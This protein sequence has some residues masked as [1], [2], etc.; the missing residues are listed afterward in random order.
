MVCEE[1]ERTKQ[2]PFKT[3][4]TKRDFKLRKN[5]ISDAFG[6]DLHYLL[7]EAIDSDIDHMTDWL[8]KMDEPTKERMKVLR[9]KLGHLLA[10]EQLLGGELTQDDENRFWS[11]RKILQEVKNHTAQN[12]I[13]MADKRLQKVK[14]KKGIF[15]CELCGEKFNS[16]GDYCK[17]YYNHTLS[18]VIKLETLGD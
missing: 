15:P 4:W 18:Q 3:N 12:A 11:E 7:R 16:W 6:K 10:I 2:P 5:I 1:C 17:H 8:V 14:D 9:E 13:D